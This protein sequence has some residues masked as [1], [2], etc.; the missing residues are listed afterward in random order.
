MHNMWG[1]L[2]R[3][4]LPWLVAAGM[5]AMT[6]SRAAA[7]TVVVTDMRVGAYAQA[8]RVVFD[9]SDQLE[10]TV[11]MLANPYRVVIDM[12]EVGW[13]LPPRPLPKQTG[14]FDKLRYGRFQVGQ[15]RVVLDMVKP[16]AIAN[17]FV[18]K[19]ESGLPHRLV[20]DLVA[21]T[22][23][24]FAS[25]L[26]GPALLVTADRAYSAPP[27]VLPAPVAAAPKPVMSIA[28]VVASL[29]KPSSEP[30]APPPPV[31]STVTQTS[32]FR[33]A[34]RKPALRPNGTKRV[35]VI[36]PGHGGVD[37]G[38]IGRSGVY[39]KHITLALGRELKRRLDASGRYRAVLTRS[40]DIFI[41]LRDRVQIARDAG[42]DLFI[43]IHA[44][45]IK[46]R[47][48]SGASVY[49]L[50]ERAS[51]KEAAALAEKENKADLIA[52]IDLSHESPE[53]ANILIDLAQR[54]SM[55]Q[56]SSFAGILVQRL[57][58]RARVLRNTHRFAGFAVLR[59]PDVPSVLLESGFLSNRADEKRLR[60]KA[61]RA[62]IA[63]AAVEALD[64]YFTQVE[65][66]TSR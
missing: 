1:K 47:A 13:R 21:T 7:A 10:F 57:K 11:F 52:G 40:R 23:S 56:S 2:S 26:K 6:P 20:L 46:D 58:H 51:D 5:V 29:R 61:Y 27:P 35:V 12:P 45:T 25:R 63:T 31:L 36:D 66:A 48:I 19:P 38:T 33:L 62:K 49:T 14:L 18:L 28:E 16:V 55:N 65:E 24:A 3:C 39:E 22:E 4:W 9:F 54:E 53:V 32:Q 44:D 37:P 30:S 15:S 64:A 8:T 43:S 17:A 50:S 41:R 34:P 42:A 60:S 59:A